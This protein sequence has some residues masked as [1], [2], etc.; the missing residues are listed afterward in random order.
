MLPRLPL[1]TTL[2]YAPR[3]IHTY[4]RPHSFCACVCMCVAVPVCVPVYGSTVCTS[5]LCLCVHRRLCLCLCLSVCAEGH[6]NVI[7]AIVPVCL[8]LSHSAPL[9]VCVRRPHPDSEGGMCLWP[10]GHSLSENNIDAALL[11]QIEAFMQQPVAARQAEGTRPPSSHRQSQRRWL[12]QYRP[13]C[14]YMGHCVC[15]LLLL[16]LAKYAHV[17]VCVCAGLP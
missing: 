10:R 12:L 5:A 3:P 4:A 6:D 14:V 16:P 7:T 1:L 9:C 15:L 2:G 13:V 17:R 8:S 11:E